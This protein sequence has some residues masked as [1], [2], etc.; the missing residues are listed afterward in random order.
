MNKLI[1][2]AIPIYEYAGKGTDVLNFSLNQLLLQTFQDFSL[3]ISDHSVDD[4]IEK[5]CIRWSN[6]FDL[7]YLRNEN[8]RGSGAANFNNCLKN[9]TGKIIKLMCADDFVYGRDALQIIADN[10]TD[11]TDFLATSYLHS[12]DRRNYYNPHYPQ[13]N[14]MIRVNNTIGT[15]SC[16]SIRRYD[17]IPKF[18][19]NLKYAFDCDFYHQYI[20]KYGRIKFVNSMGIVNYIWDFSITANIDNEL[21]KSESEYILKKY[22]NTTS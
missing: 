9:C 19:K 10:F 22:A 5:E 8:D 17:D 1:N 11:D 6:Y 15:P 4:A 12:R 3:I 16:V 2:I 13:M 14:D 18:D 7:K 21:I 20:G